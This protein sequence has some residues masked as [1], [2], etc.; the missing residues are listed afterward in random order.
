MTHTQKTELAERA[1]RA[2]ARHLREI[3]KATAMV[4]RECDNLHARIMENAGDYGVHRALQPVYDRLAK[5]RMASS[6]LSDEV[7]AEK[8]RLLAEWRLAQNAA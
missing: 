8:A 1:Y 5:I 6:D 7:R 2:A 3:N 4:D